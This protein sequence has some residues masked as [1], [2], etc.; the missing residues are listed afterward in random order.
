MMDEAQPK[1]NPNFK[2]VAS[3]LVN[4]HAGRKYAL[5]Q[6]EERCSKPSPLLIKC[7]FI[8]NTF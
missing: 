7:G 4:T 1:S 3:T 5:A 8:Q 2:T 6:V